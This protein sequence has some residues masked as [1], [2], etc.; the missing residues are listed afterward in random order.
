M[1]SE[2]QILPSAIYYVDLR[3]LHKPAELIEARSFAAW[4]AP[5]ISQQC[6]L[7]SPIGLSA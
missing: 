6:A 1:T 4:R 7:S 3:A 2:T 5:L